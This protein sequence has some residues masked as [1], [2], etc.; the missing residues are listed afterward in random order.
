MSTPQRCELCG[1]D[2]AHDLYGILLRCSS[3]GLV[4]TR[5]HVAETAAPC[6]PYDQTYFTERNAYLARAL[7]F[8]A[9]FETLLDRIQRHQ[10]NGEL[11][12]V[13]CGPALL[14]KVA[15]ERGYRTS[16]CDIS[17]WA[18]EYARENGFDVRLG[19]LES[20]QF[21]SRRFDVVVINHTLEHVTHP[22]DLLREA[23]RV[24]TDDG[25]LLVGVPNFDS[26][27]AHLMRTRW[28]GLLPD[29][30][31]W[32]F[33]PRTLTMMLQR[34]GFSC[35]KMYVDSAFHRHPDQM[36]QAVLWFVSA[37][38]ALLRRGE[39]QLVIARKHMG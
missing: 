18:V 9:V 32:H 29:Q 30:H 11:L 26:L 28:A 23:R 3:C 14:L 8:H 20:Q 24:L 37:A 33:T 27:M 36:K 25:I 2:V 13:G 1:S 35:Q 10:P 21:E 4:R 22:L 12:D 31:L 6:E 39:A 15:Q 19:D 34:A 38:G 7:S 5:C 17:P 16:G